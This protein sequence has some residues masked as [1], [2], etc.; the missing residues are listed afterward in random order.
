MGRPARSAALPAGY[1]VRAAGVLWRFSRPHTIVG[2]TLSV[3]G[4]YLIAVAEGGPAGG[5]GD[6]AATLVAALTVNVAIVGLN[7]LTD[8]EIDRVNK[9]HLPVA[10]GDLSPAAG[11]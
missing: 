3:L 1:P 5:A 2:T 8:I 6:L 7:Q 10:A 11:A 4:L 9:P